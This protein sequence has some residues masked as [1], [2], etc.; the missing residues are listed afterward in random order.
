MD[1]S[2]HSDGADYQRAVFGAVLCRCPN[3]GDPL[4]VNREYAS[5]QSTW[6]VGLHRQPFDVI[7]ITNILA[8]KHNLDFNTQESGMVA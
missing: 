6:A 2:S 8:T 7:Y 5:S 3:Q 1:P 4:R